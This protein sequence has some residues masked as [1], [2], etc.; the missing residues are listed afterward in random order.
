MKKEFG[1]MPINLKEE[2]EGEFSSFSWQ[3]FVTAIPST[4]FLVTTY[5]DNGR[6]NACLQSWSTFVGDG[7]EFICILGSV[8][9]RGHLY[10]SL[11][12][13]K[14]CVLNFPSSDI[15][16]KC[17]QTIVNNGY[18]DEEITMSG[19]TAEKAMT[20]YAPRIKECFLN[21]E[22]ELLWE[23]EHFEGCRD[24]VIA[25]K[26]KHISMDSDFYDENKKGRYGRTGFM[27]NVNSPK[28]PETGGM[29]GTCFGAIEKY[30]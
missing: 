15:Y 19:L 5:K 3:D 2:W 7:G 13:T 14:E 11:L 27:Y 29:Y 22:C 16:K 8:S 28:N 24:V 12:C 1:S 30:E 10:K 4:L 9:K 20:V 6:E 23:K 18:D 26:A 21:I 17:E 25:L